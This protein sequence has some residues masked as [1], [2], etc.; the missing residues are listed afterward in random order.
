M[1]KLELLDRV[2][3]C[4]GG[5][6]YSGVIVGRYDF[7]DNLHLPTAYKVDFDEPILYSGGERTVYMTESALKKEGERETLE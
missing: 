2:T 1:G 6:A 7:A 3:Y 5:V 4:F